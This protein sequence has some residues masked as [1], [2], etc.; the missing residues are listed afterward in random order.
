MARF[1]HRFFVWLRRN[2]NA[3]LLAACFLVGFVLGVRM[4]CGVDF[5]VSLMRGAMAGSVSIVSLLCVLLLPLLFSALAVY[6]SKPRLL[7]CIAFVKAFAFA[8]V[9]AAITSGFASAGWLA[10]WLLMF[11]DCLSLPL[12]WMYWLRHVP[13]RRAFQAADVSVIAGCIG[14]VGLCDQILVMPLL[15]GI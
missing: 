13:G 8:F 3:A 4:S 6:F 9:S 12:L 5:S 15:Q 1:L 10:R 2:A 7:Y 14:L 11:S